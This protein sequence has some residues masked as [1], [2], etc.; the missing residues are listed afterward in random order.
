MGHAD[1]ANRAKLN[2]KLQ[3][4]TDEQTEPLRI[5]VSVVEVKNVKLAFAIQWAM[6]AQTEG[7]APEA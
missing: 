2:Q 6:S 5:K 3:E 4:V 1:F 7:R